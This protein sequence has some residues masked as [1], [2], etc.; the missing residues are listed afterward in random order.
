MGDLQ[1]QFLAEQKKALSDHEE[2]FE[3]RRKEVLQQMG[4][5][6]GEMRDETEKSSTEIEQNL[7]NTKLTIDKAKSLLT[8]VQRS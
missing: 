5:Y 1:K 8:M 3:N 7:I 6:V 4:G 2:K